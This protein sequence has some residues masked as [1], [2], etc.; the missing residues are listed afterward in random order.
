MFDVISKLPNEL[1]AQIFSFFNV[2]ELAKLEQVSKSWH[3]MIRK[4]PTL[5]KDDGFDGQKVFDVCALQHEGKY[6]AMLEKS[7]GKLHRIFLP[8]YLSFKTQEEIEHLLNHLIKSE[9][10]DLWIVIR[11]NSTCP[12]HHRHTETDWT[13]K[14]RYQLREAV[15]TVIRTVVQCDKLKHLRL[16]AGDRVYVNIQ[17]F[18]EPSKWPFAINRLRKLALHNI[19]YDSLFPCEELYQCISEV[20]DIEFR[21][22]GRP[23]NVIDDERKDIWRFISTAKASLKRCR[24]RYTMDNRNSNLATFTPATYA[25]PQMEQLYLSICEMQRTSTMQYL[26][27]PRLKVLHAYT[28][29]QHKMVEQ[30][31]C[32]SL[33]ELHIGLLPDEEQDR[34]SVLDKMERCTKVKK[35]IIKNSLGNADIE[36]MCVRLQR[37]PLEEVILNDL[38]PDSILKVKKMI[39]DRLSGG[40]F[41][42][43]QKATISIRKGGPKENEWLKKHVPKVDAYILPDRIHQRDAL[44]REQG[45]HY[46]ELAELLRS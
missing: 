16:V 22:T 24:V 34:K 20:E 3:T 4:N 10:Q 28:V 25:F 6:K 7:H 43:I 29:S 45:L 36:E 18:G 41:T 37:S 14:G 21:S 11:V 1:F 27:C 17:D 8:V 31:L 39:N 9:V 23:D 5:W 19:N 12:D 32:N 13:P 46:F 2:F 42:K 33:E 40:S 15:K 26:K 30:L 38:S 44:F 35:W